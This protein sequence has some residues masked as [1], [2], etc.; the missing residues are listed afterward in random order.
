MQQ[1]KTFLMPRHNV[2]IALIKYVTD[3]EQIAKI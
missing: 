1:C 3:Y 2:E